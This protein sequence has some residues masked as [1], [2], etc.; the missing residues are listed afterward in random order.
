MLLSLGVPT[1]E[2]Q[3]IEAA[4]LKIKK[5]YYLLP[6]GSKRLD[7]L[8]NVRINLYKMIKSKASLLAVFKPKVGR[9]EGIELEIEPEIYWQT[10]KK[11]R[12][13]RLHNHR[14]KIEGAFEVPENAFYTYT[15]S[16]NAKALL[17]AQAEALELKLLNSHALFG[18]FYYVKPGTKKSFT[19]KLMPPDRIETILQIKPQWIISG[20]YEY[21]SQAQT[22]QLMPSTA[23]CPSCSSFKNFFLKA[24]PI[25]DPV[26]Y[27]VVGFG[28]EFI[29]IINETKEFVHMKKTS[30]FKLYTK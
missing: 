20:S 12:I 14:I 17:E 6:D 7:A 26:A 1:L 19:L 24:L 9:Y 21:K 25:P 11:E 29:D 13:Q 5:L 8:Q 15:L 23:Q 10:G 22:V 27:K 30:H 16:W 3:D 28:E 18:I 2:A 4:Y